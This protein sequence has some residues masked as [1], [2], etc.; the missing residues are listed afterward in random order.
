V[1]WAESVIAAYEDANAAGFGSVSVDGQMVDAASIK[2]AQNTLD[3]ARQ[4]D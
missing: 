1:E 4:G 3:L 2:M